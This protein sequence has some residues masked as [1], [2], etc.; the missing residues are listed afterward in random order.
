M[1]MVQH[2]PC[3]TTKV[4][5][6][7][8]DV[9]TSDNCPNISDKRWNCSGRNF[10]QANFNVTLKASAASQ[11][12]CWLTACGKSRC[13][14]KF[15]HHPLESTHFLRNEARSLLNH[16]FVERSKLTYYQQGTFTAIIQNN[17]HQLTASAKK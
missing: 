12:K 5:T 16:G 13:V 9:T 15:R 7:S 8:W 6:W 3:P 10:T 1:E 17:V 14:G 4:E 11:S 2:T